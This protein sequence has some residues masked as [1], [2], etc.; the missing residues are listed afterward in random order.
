[1]ETSKGI[2]LSSYQKNINWDL[3]TSD[4]VIIK[5]AE[6]LFTDSCAE[7]HAENAAAKGIKKSYYYFAHPAKRTDDGILA[8]NYFY[9]VIKDLPAP[10]FACALDLEINPNN[11]SKDE[12][13]AWVMSFVTQMGNYGLAIM[14][15]GSPYFLNEHLPVEHSLGTLPLWLSE[16]NGQSAPTLFPNG[17]TQ[18]SV[19][20]YSDRG[21]DGGIVNNLDVNL[22][23]DLI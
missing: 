9:D 20:Q 10:D 6:D 7:T 3:V 12:M 11:L 13:G 18:C 19:W 2:D 1:M 14:L 21:S 23:Y 8:A 22:C 5:A 17:W 4:F 15:Y 16:Y